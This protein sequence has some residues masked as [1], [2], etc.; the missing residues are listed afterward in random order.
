MKPRFRIIRAFV[1]WFPWLVSF[2]YGLTMRVSYLVRPRGFLP[3]MSNPNEIHQDMSNPNHYRP[4]PVHGLL[5]VLSH[6]KVIS[7]RL[8][9]RKP[10][11]DC[12]DHGIYWAACLMSN[13][14]AKRVWFCSV[15]Y[16]RADG[17]H[18]GHVICAWED[19]TGRYWWAD[20]DPPVEIKSP[21]GWLI[22]NRPDRRIIGAMMIPVRSL[23]ARGTPR[24]S[25][26]GILRRTK[27]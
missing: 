19:H 21:W 25:W 12:D 10:V 2:W 15:Q 4:D 5:D 18:G 16:I 24:L 27:F 1:R 23:T 11:G 9:A 7:S 8:D 17:S 6:P 26:R 3:I 14:L 20:Y 22:T 13:N